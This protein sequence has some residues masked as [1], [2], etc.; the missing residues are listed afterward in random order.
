MTEPHLPKPVSI[1]ALFDSQGIGP[2]PDA[3]PRQELHDAD[4][5]LGVDVMSERQFFM[6]GREALAEIMRTRKG[7]PLRV[8]RIAID[9]ET[10]ELEKL[11]ALVRVIKGRCDYESSAE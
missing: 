7:R 1:H 5:I 4:V 9:Q 10:D 6:Y 8:A 2:N 11:S 3:D